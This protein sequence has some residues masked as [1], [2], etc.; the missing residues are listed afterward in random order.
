[1]SKNYSKFKAGITLFPD[2]NPA[3]N[4]PS[5]DGD[6]RYNSSTNKIEIYDGAVD[7][8]V[9]E[10]GSTTISNKTIDNTNTIFIKDSNF[11]IENSADTT[12][13]IQ[14]S[15]AG[16]T[17]GQTRVFTVPDANTTLV[18]IDTTQTLTNKSIDATAN[19]IS[20]L[21][22]SN[23]NGSAAI[24]NANLA[25]MPANTVKA[26]VTGSSAVPTDVSLTSNATASAAM[27]RDANAN[28]SVNN[29]IEGYTSTATAAGTTALSVSSTQIQIFTG[30]TTQTVTL[31]DCTTLVL[32]QQY[33]ITNRSSGVVTV[34]NFSNSLVQ[35]MAANT[36]IVATCTNIASSAGAWDITYTANTAL[37]NPMTTG[38]DTIYGGAGGTPTRL[39]NGSS[40]QVYTS[41]GGTAAPSWNTVIPDSNYYNFLVNGAFDYWQAG[42]STT[43]TSAGGASPTNVYAYQADQWY[44]NNKLGGATTEGVITY[45][46]VLGSLNGSKYGAQ[47]QI[48]TAPVGTGAQNGLELYQTLSNAETIQLI[49][50]NASFSIQVQALNHV[51]QVGIQFMYATGENKVNTAIGS[52]VLTTVNS[53]GF[54]KCSIN[55]QAIGNAMFTT[56]VVGVRIRPTAVSSGNLYDLNNGFVVEQA[57]LNLG[58]TATPFQRQ[59]NNPV[60]E[61]AACQYFYEVLNTAALNNKELSVGVVVT[62]NLT[63]NFTYPFKVVKRINPSISVSSASHFN[64]ANAATNNAT[65]AFAD[66]GSTTDTAGLSF[67]LSG[68]YA[69]NSSIVLITNNTSARVFFDARI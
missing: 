57:M 26:N 27:I 10:A 52:E 50:Q 29:L 1:M 67:S 14:F 54:T 21:S 44:V 35:S 32:G 59:N 2:A 47:V 30:S 5:E 66:N 9:T 37:S 8:L 12:K 56:G 22:N 46:R 43:I 68:T 64:A 45:S 19:T 4:P 53:S 24:S 49:L 39:A 11:T 28:V 62:A 36:S 69:G 61:L 3:T 55:G 15:A 42:T 18:G 17:S 25:A 41:N 51:T 16:I 38:G 48:T 58:N 33:Y 65:T 31:P 34:N 23:L 60:Q 40:G 13:E 7:S 20:N 6:M 63:A